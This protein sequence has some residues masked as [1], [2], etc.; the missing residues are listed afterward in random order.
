MTSNVVE[1]LDAIDDAAVA[2]GSVAEF[3]D[4]LTEPMF[5]VCSNGKR[6]ACCALRGRAVLAALAE[7][8]G[9]RTWECTHLGGHR[10]AANMVC[11]PDGIVYGRVAPEHAG[12][13]ADD[14]A[15]GLLDPAAL[16]GRSA[17]PA[18]AQVAEQHVRRANG[19]RGLDDV[20]LLG[21]DARDAEATVDLSVAGGVRR[22]ALRSERTS[23]PRPTSCRADEVDE[24][25]HWRVVAG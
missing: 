11:L 10:F 6:D 23:P 12:R 16:R 7:R 1:S 20:A 4:P 22:V 15:A 14:F 18:P 19:A 24:P 25:L 13:L 9:E 2:S 17:W 8:H 3:G 21:V 5:L